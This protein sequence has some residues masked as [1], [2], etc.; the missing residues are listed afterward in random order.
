MCQEVERKIAT[1]VITAAIA[2]GYSITV[3]DGDDDVI[4]RSK[5]IEAILA[6]M[7]STG[8]DTLYMY[9]QDRCFGWVLFIYG[10]GGWDVI[11]DYTTNLEP[12]MGE[13]K[14]ISDHYSS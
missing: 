9:Q 12:I 4:V 14:A 13:A 3:D 7:F 2:A 6:S 8:Q 11:N 5:D 1:A 10:W